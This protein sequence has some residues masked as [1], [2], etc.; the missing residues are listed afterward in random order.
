MSYKIVF[1]DIDGTILPPDHI[2]VESTKSAVKQLQEKGVIVCIATGRPTIDTVKVAEEIGVN[3]YIT[4]NGACVTIED[5][6][7]YKELLATEDVEQLLSTAKANDHDVLLASTEKNVIIPAPNSTKA[8]E[9]V[10]HLH[11]HGSLY[12]TEEDKKEVL[13]GTV[14]LQN[15]NEATVYDEIPSIHLVPCNIGGFIAYDFISPNINK[16][17]AIDKVL[18]HLNID[19]ADTIAF[20][21]G[22]NDKEMLSYV[23]VGIAMG[24]AHED[25]QK[26]ASFTTTPVT[27][28]GIYNGLKIL[29]LVD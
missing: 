17:T 9:Y 27:E 14:L 12:N 3:S 11:M 24:N 20:G 18:K 4:F 23:K 25:L 10:Q 26:F 13:S 21:D 7:I 16:A 22:M 15:H 6:V 19:Q 2:I 1:L 28:D 29:G 8:T 5:K